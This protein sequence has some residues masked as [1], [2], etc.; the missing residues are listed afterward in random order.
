MFFLYNFAF[1]IY[2]N[3]FDIAKEALDQTVLSVGGLLC[4]RYDHQIK[5]ERTA[6]ARLASRRCGA[7]LFIVSVSQYTHICTV[8]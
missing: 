4:N 5:F 2:F 3:V 7:F 6:T 1:S 8:S